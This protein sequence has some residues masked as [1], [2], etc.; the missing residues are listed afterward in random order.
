MACVSI[1]YW[2]IGDNG[3]YIT[4]L[5]AA[6]ILAGARG[7]QVGRSVDAFDCIEAAQIVQADNEQRQRRQNAKSDRELAADVQ[8]SENG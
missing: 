7:A 1:V 4:C 5:G 2:I 6:Q 8:V 3:N